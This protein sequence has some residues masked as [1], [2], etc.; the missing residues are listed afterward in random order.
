MLIKQFKKGNLDNVI[1]LID[2]L[3]ELILNSF[4]NKQAAAGEYRIFDAVSLQILK[5]S[6]L[7][8]KIISGNNLEIFQQLWKGKKEVLGTL[9]SP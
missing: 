4:G 8:I 7:S 3:K 5:R 9:I 2:E 6:K 1:K